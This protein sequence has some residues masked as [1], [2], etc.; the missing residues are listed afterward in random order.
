MIKKLT[1]KNYHERHQKRKSIISF[2]RKIKT[3]DIEKEWTA[4]LKTLFKLPQM[5]N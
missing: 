4:L 3:I 5:R 1:R 2:W